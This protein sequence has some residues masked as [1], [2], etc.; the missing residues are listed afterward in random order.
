M[1]EI[2]LVQF[3]EIFKQGNWGK[4]VRRWNVMRIQFT[5]RCACVNAYSTLHACICVFLYVHIHVHMCTY[6]NTRI[7]IDV[8]IQVHMIK[9][10]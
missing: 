2:L 4:S 3:D 5:Q 6:T 9:C 8:N 1:A 10:V 7:R